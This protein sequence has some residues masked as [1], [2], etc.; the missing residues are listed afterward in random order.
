M[1][2]YKEYEILKRKYNRLLDR[3]ML[4]EDDN[5]YLREENYKLKITSE[6]IFESNKR[7]QR[8]I[9]LTKIRGGNR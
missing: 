4:L 2:L 5:Q 8:E 6:M 7:L 1:T 9:T 3:Y